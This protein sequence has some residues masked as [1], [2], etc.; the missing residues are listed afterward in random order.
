MQIIVNTQAVGLERDSMQQ[1][2]KR[3]IAIVMGPMVF[4]G[5]E[6]ALIEMLNVFDYERTDVT[7]FLQDSTGEMEP[8][9]NSRAKI[10]YW[11]EISPLQALKSD[12]CKGNIPRVF[13]TLFCR[14]MCR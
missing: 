6:K 7:V 14:F 9:I 11:P 12:F 13:Y 5:T 4:G 1:L 2:S 3:K 8:L 10:R